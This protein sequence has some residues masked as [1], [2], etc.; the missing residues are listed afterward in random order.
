MAKTKEFTNI[1]SSGVQSFGYQGKVKV[2]LCRGNQILST[3]EYHN[4]GMPDLF[5]FLANALA[6]NYLSFLRPVKIKLFK[7]PHAETTATDPDHLT[8]SN[9]KWANCWG[10]ESGYVDKPPVGI[11]P[12]ILYDVAPVVK[13][14]LNEGVLAPTSDDYHYET[15]FHF[16]IPFSYISDTTA[17][18]VG[19]FPNEAVDDATEVS[20]YYLFTNAEGTDWDPLLIPESTGNFSIIIEWTMSISNK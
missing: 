8:V 11:T 9:F 18:A 4:N 17:H 20:A 3:K 5:K 15:T 7:F 1:I 19:F 13:K 12:Y 10:A 16:R 6:G 14:V 2:S